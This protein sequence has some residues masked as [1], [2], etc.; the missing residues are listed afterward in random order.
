[1]HRQVDWMTAADVTILEFLNAARDVRGNPSIQRPS[2]I[3]DNTGHARKYV[4]ERCRHLADH[5][6]VEQLERGKYRLSNRGEQLMDGSLHP[7]DL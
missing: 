7:D 2:T 6:L 4:G 5:G 1:M 3:S